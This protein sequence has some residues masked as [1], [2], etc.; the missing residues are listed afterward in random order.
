M[1]PAAIVF[2]AFGGV[3]VL[4]GGYEAINTLYEWHQDRKE[5]K[6]YEEYVKAHAEKGRCVP[7]TLFEDDEEEED[8]EPLGLWKQRTSELRHRN[9]TSSQYELHEME[10][11]ISDRKSI[12]ER[13]REIL[14][15]QEAELERKKSLVESRGNSI[16]GVFDHYDDDDQENP[17]LDHHSN[18]SMSI[19]SLDESWS[20]I[21]EE[22][23]K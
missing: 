23:I 10:R 19:K 17:F 5:E 22:S 6:A 8:E 11:S 21:N 12:L 20:D 7:S 4:W 1:H 3:C 18:K 13:E 2:L 9:V 16:I 14:L 15:R